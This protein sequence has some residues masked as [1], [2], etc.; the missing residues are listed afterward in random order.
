[1]YPRLV[2]NTIKTGKFFSLKKKEV[3][4]EETIAGS[5]GKKSG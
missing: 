3:L 5:I 4:I 2:W 1:M